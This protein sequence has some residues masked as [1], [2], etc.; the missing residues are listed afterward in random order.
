MAGTRRR[1]RLRECL[2]GGLVGGEIG[3]AIGGIAGDGGRLIGSL[4]GSFFGS[5]GGSQGAASAYKALTPL[6]AAPGGIRPLNC[7]IL[8]PHLLARE[9]LATRRNGTVLLQ[10]GALV[11]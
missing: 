7:P 9:P 6:F 5:L 2:L 4:G 1:R 11:G 3:G 10:E 8:T